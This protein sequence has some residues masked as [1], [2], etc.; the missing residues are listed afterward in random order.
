M[1]LAQKSHTAVVVT[2]LLTR[3]HT[4][5]D[6]DLQAGFLN[7]G[8]ACTHTDL[9]LQVGFLNVTRHWTHTDFYL[10]VGFLNV[11]RHW[12]HTDLDLQVGF[13]DPYGVAGSEALVRFPDCGD[14]VNVDV[15]VDV[16][17]GDVV[18][19]LHRQCHVP[20]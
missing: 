10:Q 14:D 11:T 3:H 6:L 13:L 7:L 12:T 16:L 20:L 1:P 15:R 5:T 4:H 9:D 2:S 8:T 18:S 19:T 17:V